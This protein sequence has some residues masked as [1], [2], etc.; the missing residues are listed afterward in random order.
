LWSN[1]PHSRYLV[2]DQLVNLF[3]LHIE[4]G[5]DIRAVNSLFLLIVEQLKG[6]RPG[7]I[8]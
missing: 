6:K 7:E 8:V 2:I 3:K 5:L 1:F 4:E